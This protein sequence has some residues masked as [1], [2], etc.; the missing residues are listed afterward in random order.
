MEI[1][2]TTTLLSIIKSG[3]PYVYALIDN[4]KP[5][6]IG[7][8]TG[9]RLFDHEKEALF[10]RKF[11]N[12]AK[13]F[14]IRK[15]IKEGREIQ[16]HVQCCN[17]DD[18]AYYLEKELIKQYGRKGIDE[19]GILLNRTEG[20]DGGNIW[21]ILSEE[22][23]SKVMAAL[24]AHIQLNGVHNE[25]Q[26]KLIS[27]NNA[28]VE[29]VGL[30]TLINNFNVSSRITY[31]IRGV[32]DEYK[33]WHRAEDNNPLQNIVKPL[34]HNP[35]NSRPAPKEKIKK[36]MV[37]VI[38][39]TLNGDYIK[40]WESSKTAS[41]ELGISQGAISNVAIGRQKSAGG[42]KWRYEIIE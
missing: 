41:N 2:T 12:P 28:I 5:F 38:Q 16:Y 3:Q 9:D 20:G 23:R 10:N 19:N 42:F 36:Q 24:Q 22:Q 11:H 21:N 13:I 27:P 35:K 40:V 31:L 18:E 30:K 25:I 39:L 17:D 33:G 26:Y 8:G 37:P 14:K 4:D 6:Y 32:I 7:K 29:G 34:F 15:I 1:I